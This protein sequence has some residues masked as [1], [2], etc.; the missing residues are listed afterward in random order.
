MDCRGSLCV[1]DAGDETTKLLIES[2]GMWKVRKIAECVVVPQELME[3]VM[4]PA[5]GCG[6]CGVHGGGCGCCEEEDEDY[7]WEEDAC[8]FL[9]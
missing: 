8:I 1:F 9:G 7:G 2:I 6:E 3:E 5:I 4:P